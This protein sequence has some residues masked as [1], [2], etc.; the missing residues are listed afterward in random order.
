[1][2]ERPVLSPAELVRRAEPMVLRLARRLH[3]RFSFLSV[4]ELAAIG[5][6]AALAATR[7]YDPALGNFDDFAV[8]R[9]RGEMIRAAM[10][11]R[12]SRPREVIDRMIGCVVPKPPPTDLGVALEE[13]PE[14]AF[15]RTVEWLQAEA[16]AL[17]VGSLLGDAPTDPED[18]LLRAEEDALARRSV[19]ALPE[20]ERRAIELC[21]SGAQTLPEI[22]QALGKDERTVRRWRDSAA[23]KLR[24][25]IL[26]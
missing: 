3:R 2:M 12:K 20:N 22:A 8:A 21:A 10:R 19:A 25:A 9:V 24:R 5:R 4:D 14:A 23:A 15:E 26:A 18:A 16:A 1:M 7:R 13:T 11:E 6:D 17:L